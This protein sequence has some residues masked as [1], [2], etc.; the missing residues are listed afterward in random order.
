MAELSAATLSRLTLLNTGL[1]VVNTLMLV[2]LLLRGGGDSPQTAP[3]TAPQTSA[4]LATSAPLSPRPMS[5]APDG[6]AVE[7]VVGFI[8]ATVGPLAAAAK[9]HGVSDPTIIPTEEEIDAA[10]ASNSLESA[11][12]QALFV[13]LKAG[14]ARFNMPFPDI[15]VPGPPG[16]EGASSAPSTPQTDRGPEIQAW[17]TPTIAHLRELLAEKGESEAGLIP[18]DAEIAAAVASGRM[19]SE[20]TRW[21]ID[22]LKNGYARLD[23][24]FPEPGSASSASDPAATSGRA[25]SESEQTLLRAYFEAQVQ[26][27]EL[28]ANKQGVNVADVLPDEAVISAA[29][30]SGDIA[31]DAA[32]PAL[33]QLR[34]GYERVGLEFREPVVA[35]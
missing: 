1:L 5:T 30:A 18:T 33:E 32:R 9:D 7:G 8:Q 6:P 17:V 14:Y 35:P 15:K 3:S 21:V 4:P 12:T 20:E 10:M 34:A 26:R 2:G 11:E 31:S 25:A 13:K 23:Q 29:V 28:N 19:D 16:A 27:L 22:K 24:P